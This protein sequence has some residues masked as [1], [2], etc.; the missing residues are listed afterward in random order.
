MSRRKIML[1]AAGLA[2]WLVVIA[3][4]FAANTVRGPLVVGAKVPAGGGRVS[5]IRLRQTVETICGTFSP[6]SHTDVENLARLADWIAARFR[7]TG[8]D[9]RFQEYSVDGRTYR[10]VVAVREGREGT[11]AGVVVM[12]AH[13]DAYGPFPGA[14]D[15]ASGVAV[16]L[17]A[18]R[19]LPSEPP[20]RRQYFV[21]FCTEEPPHFGT[22]DMGSARFARWL[23]EKGIRVQLA[24]ALDLVGYYSDDPGTQELPLPG[25]GLLYPR[26]GGFVA[27]VGD[28]GSGRPILQVKRAMKSE[29]ELSV[30][31][32]RGPRWIPGMIWSDHYP[33]RKRGIPAVLVTDTAFLRNPNYHQATDTPDTLDYHRMALVARALR[34]VVRN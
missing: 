9:V 20:R 7:E 15:N 2:F 25:M 18:V 6:R 24:V 30:Y 14:D 34:A 17:E 16:L 29:K 13:Y 4:L 3:L 1:S 12:G 21:A 5:A 27:V 28:L 11:S 26:T 19:E 33:F 23:D 8:L 31:S 22:D 10:N 32:F